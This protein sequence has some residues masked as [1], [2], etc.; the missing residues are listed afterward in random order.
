MIE[1]GLAQIAWYNIRKATPS[2]GKTALLVIDMQVYFGTIAKPVLVNVISLIE[3][4][5]KQ[6]IKVL[7]T[8]HGHSKQNDGSML[9]RWWGD[10]IMYGSKEWELID[11]LNAASDDI[12][13]KNRY[14]AFHG[15]SLDQRLKSAGIKDVIISGVMTNCCVE[16]TARSAFDHDYGVFVVAD[17]CA[18]ADGGLHIASLKDLAYGFAYIMDTKGMLDC[19]Y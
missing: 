14:N 1:D 19:L 16:S 10:L 7:F 11:S 17:A 8:R 15:T 3:A 13:D 9:S 12:V 2:I 6:G 5:R 18:A 4:C